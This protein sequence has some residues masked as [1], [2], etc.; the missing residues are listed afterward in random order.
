M[1][2]KLKHYGW[3]R[4]GEGMTAEEHDFVLGRYRQKFGGDSFDT[5]AVPRL[6]DLALRTPCVTPPHDYAWRRHG[7]RRPVDA[8]PYKLLSS[9]RI[10]VYHEGGGIR[11]FILS[12]RRLCDPTA[13]LQGA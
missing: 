2:E 11:T 3:G 10:L 8:D 1:G 12:G 7:F 4:E 6:E 9:P 5:I 13:K